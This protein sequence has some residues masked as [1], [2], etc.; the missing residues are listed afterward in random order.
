MK[1]QIKSPRP[2]HHHTQSLI[3]T[4]ILSIIILAVFIA[5][6]SCVTVTSPDGITTKSPDRELLREAARAIIT[7]TK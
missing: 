1:P 5:L 2:D 3:R 6:T 4:L 7:Y